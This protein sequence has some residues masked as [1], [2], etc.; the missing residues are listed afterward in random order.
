MPAGDLF[1]SDWE[2]KGGHAL[3]LLTD[4]GIWVTVIRQLVVAS[5]ATQ[6][7]LRT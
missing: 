5:C 3:I 2:E 4:S 6:H 1:D 7:S